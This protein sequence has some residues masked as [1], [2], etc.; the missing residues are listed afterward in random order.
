MA[1]YTIQETTLTNIGAA[2]REKTGKSDLIAPGDMPAEIRA[3]VS[4]GGDIEFEPIKLTGAQS[5]GC[6]GPIA[7]EYIKIC[8]DTISTEGLTDVGHMFERSTLERIPFAINMNNTTYCDM[9]QMFSGCSQLKEVPVINNVYPTS[10]GNMFENCHMLRE[11]PEGFGSDWNWNRL[12]TYN[13]GK[14]NSFFASCH[15]LRKVPVDILKNM[16]GIQ[17]TTT[18]SPL[19]YAFSSCY[20]LDEI[21]DFPI[22]PTTLTSNQFDTLI[23]GCHRLKSFTFATNE[24]GTPKIAQWKNQTFETNKYGMYPLGYATKASLITGYNSG[25]TKDKEVVDDASYQAL[26]NDP[27]WFTCKPAYS[28]YNHD[29]AVETINSLPD[30]SATGTNTIKFI[31]AAGS[32]TDG[33]A[34]N[35]LTE[36]EIAVAAAK[37][38]TVSFI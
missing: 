25:I 11:F 3:I 21:R 23:Q 12:H 6:A 10:C 20:A 29:S 8:G 26:K 4:G 34:I 36:E 24:D 37:G 28:R 19:G 14:F 13:Y 27:D 35:T 2:I 31:G 7:A 5:Y 15:S 17:T 1:V 38:W 32:A 22:Q 9:N 30:C 33:G 16:W 18:Y